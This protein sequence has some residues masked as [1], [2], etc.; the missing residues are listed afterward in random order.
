M[1]ATLRIRNLALVP[2]L[3]V[4]LAPGYNVITGETGA[5]KSIIIGAL[6]LIL[7]ERADRNLI[8]AGADACAVE[9][10][11][12]LKDRLLSAIND[13]LDLKG[14]ERCED[15]QLVL[16]RAF[17]A[18]GANKQFI[19]GSATTL[20]TLA[21][22]GALL[23]DIHGPHEHQSL[24]HGREQLWILDAFGAL[25]PLRDRVTEL[26]RKRAVLGQQ[27]TE[28][29]VDERSYA[30]QLDLL[31]FQV[32]EIT[33]AKLTAGEE[34]QLESDYK[35]ASNAAR[36][37]ELSQAAIQTIT[38]EE[39]SLATQMAALG[40]S[41]KDLERIDSAAST[42]S[43]THHQ[44][45]E[46]LGELQRDLE[47]YAE[48]VEVDPDRL[49]ELEARLDLLQSL[50]RKY[51]SSV[52]E[53]IEFGNDAARKLHS[54]ESRDE[55]LEKLNE[56]ILATEKELIKAA[57]EL[58]SARARAI[59]KLSKAVATQL[60]DL[61]FRQSNFSVSLQSTQAPSE[62][63]STGADQIEFLFAPNPG[64]PPRPLR[65]IA[66][67]GELARVMLALK[68]VLASLDRIP[69]LVFD[70]VD[71][72]VGGETASAVGEKMRQIG[73]NRQVLCITHL[74]PVAAAARTHFVVTKE[75][76]EGRTVSTLRLLQPKE[77][78]S[79][80]AR[81]LGGQFEAARKHAEELL[82]QATR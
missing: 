31:R 8:R 51:G 16:K 47:Q 15:G 29:I 74:P 55:Q 6:N 40:R 23:V 68:T 76:E 59:P 7:G 70:E 65:A 14:V 48:R 4:E 9:A 45:S 19:N 3:T 24:L 1:L 13:L 27:K 78:V 37:I 67:S 60:S 66:S 35:R 79:E 46:L 25:E 43:E 53:I 50:K 36:L 28:L 11:F 22:T 72:N 81:M 69:V 57:R 30:Q 77:R 17:T 18:A 12:A 21:E 63:S 42:F 75:L 26:Y 41:L 49:R 38:S 2:D 32:K 20:A 33:G 80:I 56:Q 52:A 61:G 62:L 34:E 71:A 58:S 54:L 10:V 73:A 64:E 39:T 5:G 82:K 44:L